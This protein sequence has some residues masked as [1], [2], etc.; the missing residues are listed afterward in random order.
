[1]LDN[2]LT[3]SG[4]NCGTAISLYSPTKSMIQVLV[5][6]DGVGIRQSLAQNPLYANFSEAEAI[7]KRYSNGW[8]R[9]GLWTLFNIKAHKKCRNTVGDSFGNPCF[10]V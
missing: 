9:N 10:S 2:V 6:D 5:A 7:E 3:H 8:E 1:M 4:K